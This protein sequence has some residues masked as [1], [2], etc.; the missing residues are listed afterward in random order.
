MV[1]AVV[2]R[3]GRNDWALVVG[4]VP[5]GRRVLAAPVLTFRSREEA[6]AHGRRHGLRVLD[7]GP[8]GQA[9]HSSGV[10]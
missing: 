2:A 9:S 6:R 3:V 8:L 1:D 10:R 5:A 4:H 7:R